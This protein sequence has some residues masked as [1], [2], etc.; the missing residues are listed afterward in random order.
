MAD[1]ARIEI[2]LREDG[3]V[4]MRSAFMERWDS[5]YTPF[6]QE[7]LPVE[8]EKLARE[9]RGQMVAALRERLAASEAV[10]ATPK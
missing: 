2:V 6:A 10:L 9:L 7:R 1:M 8:V 4:D 5:T 3:R